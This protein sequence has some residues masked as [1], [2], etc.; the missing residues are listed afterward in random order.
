MP[1]SPGLEPDAWRSASCLGVPAVLVPTDDIDLDYVLSRARVQRDGT[2]VAALREG[3]VTL[4]QH[5]C[6]DRADEI[7]TS[8]ALRWIEVEVLLDSRRL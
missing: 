1:P 4:Y 7:W 5:S 3:T 8:S 6:A 2:C